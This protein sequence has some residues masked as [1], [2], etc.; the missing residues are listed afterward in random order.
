[1]YN[2]A[3]KFTCDPAKR[4]KTITERGIDIMDAAEIFTGESFSYQDARKDYGECRMITV[5]FIKGRMVVV[6]WTP[7]GDSRHIISMRKANER[8]QRKYSEHFKPV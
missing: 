6:V 8:E 1:M 2:D 7:R 3:M 4:A 5:G